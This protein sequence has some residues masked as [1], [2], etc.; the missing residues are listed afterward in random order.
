MVQL[1]QELGQQVKLRTCKAGG[2][3]E[4]IQP[5]GHQAKHTLN[6]SPQL[7]AQPLSTGG[8][9]TLPPLGVPTDFV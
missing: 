1:G 7:L 4:Y 6:E 8:H 3:G 9:T 5:Q 2:G